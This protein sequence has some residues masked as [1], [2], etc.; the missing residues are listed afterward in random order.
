MGRLATGVVASFVS[1]PC[2][3]YPDQSASAR[4]RGSLVPAF[5]NLRVTETTV[6]PRLQA[7]GRRFEPGT[8]HRMDRSIRRHDGVANQ[9]YVQIGE[10]SSDH[11]AVF[12]AFDC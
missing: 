5:D 2:P 11:A 12:A 6:Q 3:K 8:L 4:R 9:P 10:P 1:D 7:G